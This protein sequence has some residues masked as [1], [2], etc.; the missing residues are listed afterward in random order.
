MSQQPRL[1]IVED[2]VAFAQILGQNLMAAGF[3]VEPYA[4]PEAAL[5]AIDS[6]RSSN[7][8]ILDWRLPGITGVELLQRLRS[9][10]CHAPALMLTSHDDVFFEESAFAAG[11]VDFIAKTRSFSVILRRIEL[12]LSGRRAEIEGDT[13]FLKRGPLTIDPA[14]HRVHWYDHPVA[15]TLGEFRVTES[16][17]RAKKDVSYRQ[18]YEALKGDRLGVNAGGTHSSGADTSDE[19]SRANVRTM[20][21][22]IRQKFL[23]ADAKFDAIES[24]PGF[25]YRW[26]GAGIE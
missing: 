22:R 14:T 10:G 18:L 15:L 9:M 7:L 13:D 16:L 19:G 26:R 25:G 21:K 17:A 1:I 23:E 20:M 2:D 11:A 3:R 8:L 24:V 5:A 12:V 6:L 4:T